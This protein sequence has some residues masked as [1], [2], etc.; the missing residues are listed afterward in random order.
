V[1]AT[2]ISFSMSRWVVFRRRTVPQKTDPV[3]HRVRRTKT[4]PEDRSPR[5]AQRSLIEREG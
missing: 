2:G 3:A 1:T 5:Q 4:D